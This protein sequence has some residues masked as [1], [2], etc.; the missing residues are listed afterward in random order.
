MSVVWSTITPD[1]LNV[2][3]VKI[4]VDQVFFGR[5]DMKICDGKFSD[6]ADGGMS[7]PV[8]CVLRKRL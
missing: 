4:N 6:E 8:E 3:G 7:S 2:G 5:K 1:D